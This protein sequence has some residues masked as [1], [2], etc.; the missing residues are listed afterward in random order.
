MPKPKKNPL[1]GSVGWY[2]IPG[3][4]RPGTM[5]HVRMPDGKT[6]C[7][8]K[9]SPRAE[10]QWCSDVPG[11]AFIEC[12]RCQTRVAL[13]QGLVP[14]T[15]CLPRS[16]SKRVLFYRGDRLCLVSHAVKTKPGRKPKAPKWPVTAVGSSVNGD[17]DVVIKIN[18][19]ADAGDVL[20][21]LMIRGCDSITIQ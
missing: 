8:A 11:R 1:Q 16:R 15:R 9:H 7:G 14:P 19:P 12:R 17:P 5:T 3:S 10:F 20:E 13:A 21:T 2:G 4:R 18:S 6:L